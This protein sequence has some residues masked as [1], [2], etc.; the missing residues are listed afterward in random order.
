M[1]EH[2]LLLL[3]KTPKNFYRGKPASIFQSWKREVCRE[4]F[5]KE[6]LALKKPADRWYPNL[7]AFP[8][9]FPAMEGT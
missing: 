7:T 9:P 6:K 4:T 8:K 3:K 2:L 1:G 5:A